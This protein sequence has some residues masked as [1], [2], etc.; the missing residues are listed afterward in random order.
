MILFLDI[1]RVIFGQYVQPQ[2][3]SPSR[4]ALIPAEVANQYGPAKL[5]T[6]KSAVLLS[7]LIKAKRRLINYT[8]PASNLSS[9]TSNLFVE[10]DISRVDPMTTSY[11]PSAIGSVG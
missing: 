7:R 8:E 2:V 5:L 4:T 1:P 6:Y 11:S 3:G 10:D 9:L